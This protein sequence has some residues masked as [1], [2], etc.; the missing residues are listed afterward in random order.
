MRSKSGIEK[1]AAGANPSPEHPSGSE[2]REKPN[3]GPLG[4]P[5]PKKKQKPKRI[6]WTR[7]EHKQVMTAF[8]LALNEPKNNNTKCTYEIWRK[9]VGKHR[10]YIESNKL[11]YVRGDIIN[12]RRL[13]EAEIEDIKKTVPKQTKTEKPKPHDIAVKMKNLRPE[14]MENTVKQIRQ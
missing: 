12:K 10:P 14:H 7:E 11:E 8:Y 3:L 4:P 2:N 5:S 6:K 1:Y 9:E 13:T